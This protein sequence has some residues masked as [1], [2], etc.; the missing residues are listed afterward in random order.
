MKYFQLKTL[1]LEETI[2][3]L[4]FDCITEKN[5]ENIFKCLAYKS[6]DMTCPI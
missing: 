5:L 1:F 6:S 3:F 2:C 4:V